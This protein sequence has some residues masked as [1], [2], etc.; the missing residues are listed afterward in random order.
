MA[1]HKLTKKDLKHDSFVDTAEKSLEF[2]QKN[3]TTIGVALL[4]VVVVLVGSSYLKT[5]R[6]NARVEASY[7]LYQ[8]QIRVSEG[9]FA[10]ANALLQECIDKHGNS[11]FGRNARVSQIAALIGLGET[12]TALSKIDEHLAAIPG[13]HPSAR[14]LQLIRANVLADAGQ[15]EEAALALE[16]FIDGDLPDAVYIERRL[17]RADWLAAAGQHSESLA[18]LE[19]LDRQAKAGEIEVF[20]NDIENRL[21]TAQALYR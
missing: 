21:A 19:D 20:G 2:L 1:A 6:A 5:S 18:I 4:V 11:E 17:Q 10:G 8:G 9:D 16:P 3:A 7:M 14:D 12:E 13:D 15:P